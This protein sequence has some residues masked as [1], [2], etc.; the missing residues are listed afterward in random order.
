[1]LLQPSLLET[2]VWVEQLDRSGD[3]QT[4]GQIQAESTLLKA[5]PLPLPYP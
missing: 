4:P 2:G 1:M 5:Q 3:R